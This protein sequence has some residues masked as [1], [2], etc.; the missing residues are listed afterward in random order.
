MVDNS[1]FL[2]VTIFPYLLMLLLHIYALRP[3]PLGITPL[4]G[5]MYCHKPLILVLDDWKSIYRRIENS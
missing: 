5:H 1:G 2:C 4:P 3:F